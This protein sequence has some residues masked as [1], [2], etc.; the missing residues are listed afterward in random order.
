MVAIQPKSSYE[1]ASEIL[2]FQ[3]YQDA[4]IECRKRIIIEAC[5]RLEN[6][7][8][9]MRS[10]PPPKGPR[11]A[12]DTGV[13]AQIFPLLDL[14]L[15]EG[16]YPSLSKGVGYPRE[17]QKRS[18][19]CNRSCMS[20]PDLNTLDDVLVILNPLVF[21]S[22]GGIHQQVQDSIL[23]DVIAANADLAYSPL[24]EDA[25]R[26][27]ASKLLSTYLQG[28][29]TPRLHQALAVLIKASA[30]Q[31]LRSAL[32][33]HLSLLP[34]RPNGVRL[35][36]KFLASFYDMPT[37]AGEQS[38][39]DTSRRLLISP[40]ALEQATKLLTSVPS[41]LP[42]KK[43]YTEIAPQLLS[44]IDGESGPELSSAAASIIANGVLNKRS[45][46]APGTIGWDLLVAPVIRALQPD[47]QIL[48]PIPARDLALEMLVSQ[49]EIERSTK[50]LLALVSSNLNA[51]L[52]GRLLRPLLLS[53]WGLAAFD[54]PSV[55][56]RTVTVDAKQLL[57]I[58]L[59]R[60]GNISH[61]EL[62]RDNLLWDGESAWT[63]GLGEAGGIAI[64][65][66]A[67]EQ[68]E[69]NI[70]EMVT[71]ADIRISKFVDVLSKSE[72]DDA[73][74]GTFFR[75]SLKSL[76][77][78]EDKDNRKPSRAL[79]R[80]EQDPIKD[81][82]TVQLV[83]ALLGTFGDKLAS[84]PQQILSLIDQLLL[85]IVES[86]TTS[87]LQRISSVA[88]SLQSISNIAEQK[89]QSQ[90]VSDAEISDDIVATCVSLLNAL[91]ST[92]DFEK[93]EHVDSVLNSTLTHLRYIESKGGA[94]LSQTTLASISTTISTLQSKTTKAVSAKP[95]TT[96]DQTQITAKLVESFAN[97]PPPLQA[98]TIHNLIAIIEHLDTPLDIPGLTTI[99][100]NQIRFNQDSYVH[101]FLNNAL[102][103]LA[104][105]RSPGYPIR[106]IVAA[107]RDPD[108]QT[109][110]NG[111]L[112]LGEAL[113]TI[114]EALPAESYRLT[115][116][117]P[118]LMSSIATAC[119]AVAGR[120]STRTLEK[121]ER[122]KSERKAKVDHRRAKKEWGGEIPNLASL[123]EQED[124]E[125]DEVTIAREARDNTAVERIIQGWEGT[126]KTEDVRVRTTA[127]S[128]L[129]TVM[130]K[131]GPAFSTEL[132][133]T[134]TDLALAILTFESGEESS[135]LRRAAVLMLMSHLR[136]LDKGLET[137][138]DVPS[139]D[140]VKSLE[141]EKA[142][143]L[144]IQIDGDDL[145][146]ENATAVLESLETLRMKQLINNQQNQNYDPNNIGLTRLQGLDVQ[147]EASL[148]KKP[149]IDIIE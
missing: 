43:Y 107:F 63:F 84:K 97:D 137:Q 119:L 124:D 131:A 115:G 90:L 30:P 114:I 92:P 134:A 72:L 40:E 130:E 108:E 15:L 69:P 82:T 45:I 38:S 138:I 53:L 142:L 85:E 19:V 75:Q 71:K 65:S 117:V 50:R 106:A 78:V 139:F 49:T 128:V 99:L 76:L 66:R 135:I 122:D 89:S 140:G 1:T 44:L 147:P 33:H 20:F 6:I 121:R 104:A 28:V 67:R 18:L 32:S 79:L 11:I 94:L 87:A 56:T 81:L 101:P 111:R 47:L 83:Q 68:S 64:R 143:T 25:L 149:K 80:S 112:R 116:E 39:S 7:Q 74:V 120:R 10:A 21:T 86:I 126:G 127:L 96:P 16:V 102:A 141:V 132:I 9:A 145:V 146:R 3:K 2:A 98:R 133:T 93:D 62:I 48:A 88:M 12:L 23:L 58:F 95:T 70:I 26:L 5:T 8:N 41:S 46:G 14:I 24:R 144:A 31:W 27:V 113:H 148:G 100:L 77:H 34:L 51:A 55:V 136:A 36:L 37:P 42:E 54:G 109:E 123:Q 118:S 105:H 4:G 59:Q 52:T 13:M 57:E 125:R 35:T 91:I 29:S 60:C 103:Q 73:L 129:G 110:L 17:R 22:T 61:L